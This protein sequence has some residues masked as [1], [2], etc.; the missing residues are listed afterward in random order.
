[1]KTGKGNKTLEYLSYLSFPPHRSWRCS[2]LT[3]ED[4]EEEQTD[5]ETNAGK[6]QERVNQSGAVFPPNTTKALP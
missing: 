2:L 6:I 5:T 1:M 4:Q 3:P